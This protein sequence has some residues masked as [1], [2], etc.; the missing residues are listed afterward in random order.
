MLFAI[1]AVYVYGT[2]IVKELKCFSV[3][4]KLGS[5]WVCMIVLGLCWLCEKKK[6]KKKKQENFCI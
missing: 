2:E 3:K 6:K 1:S 4:G 5:T